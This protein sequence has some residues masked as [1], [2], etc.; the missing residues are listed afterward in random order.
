M[1]AD[2]H[3]RNL[4]TREFRNAEDYLKVA[5]AATRSAPAILRRMDDLSFVAKAGMDFED[6]VVN[7]SVG[8]V[9]LVF[10][11]FVRMMR[12]PTVMP[13]L[14][15]AS[16][17]DDDQREP[18]DPLNAASAFNGRGPAPR[19][20]SRAIHAKYLSQVALRFV[21]A[22]EHGHLDCGHWSLS[23]GRTLPE[24]PTAAN[25]TL[26]VNQLVKQALELDADSVAVR[27]T[28]YGII[29]TAQA[30]DSEGPGWDHA[31]GNPTAQLRTLLFAVYSLFRLMHHIERDA[32]ITERSHPPALLRYQLAEATLIHLLIH[33]KLGDYAAAYR[34]VRRTWMEAEKA[35]QA[36]SKSEIPKKALL[37]A[38][39]HLEDVRPSSHL[40]RVQQSWKSV[41]PKLQP[42]SRVN[43]IPTGDENCCAEE[44]RRFSENLTRESADSE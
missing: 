22:H 15:G 12:L 30:A 33:R 42:F 11:M 28:F 10:E 14:D 37:E 29:G 26:F 2:Q 25:A 18:F 43:L 38:L 7:L 27:Q 8:V 41:I 35:Y 21:I 40:S 20:R 1:S 19:A 23:S 36:I 24:F 39:G 44:T 3:V 16:E 9:L 34:S 32:D 6:E 31:F 17:L 4:L 5:A 13:E